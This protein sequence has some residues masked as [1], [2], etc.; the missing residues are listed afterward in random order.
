MKKSI[1]LVM[2]LFLMLAG[3]SIFS[4]GQKEEEA[5]AAEGPL[6]FMSTQMTPAK[7]QAFAKS[8]LLKGFTDETGIEVAFINVEYFEMNTRLSA[9]VGAK[10]VTTSLV[11]E[12]HGGLDVMN[13]AGL[14]KDL[15]GIKLPNRTFVKSLEDRSVIKG[16]KFYVPWLQATYIMAVDKKAFNYLPAGLTSEDVTNGTKK[17]TY[18]ALLEWAK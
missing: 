10:K 13:S 6:I 2:V 16:K 9:E 14:L 17:W 11:G 15:S 18:D 12:L 8:E 1:V 7:E 4:G 3:T 5:V